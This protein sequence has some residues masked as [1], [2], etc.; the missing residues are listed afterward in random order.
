MWNV[1]TVHL[2]DVVDDDE[3]KDEGER[4]ECGWAMG[5]GGGKEQGAFAVRHGLNK[6][7]Q[8]VAV[9]GTPN[10]IKCGNRG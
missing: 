2:G 4:G 8:R 10:N 5:G 9:S 3:D 7:S 6:A 1:K